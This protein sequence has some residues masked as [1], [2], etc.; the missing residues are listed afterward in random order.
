MVNQALSP[1]PQ[2]ETCQMPC[3]DQDSFCLQQSYLGYRW[4]VLRL[5]L[6]LLHFKLLTGRYPDFFFFFFLPYL[7][8]V[9]KRLDY[10][11]SVRCWI[12][13]GCKELMS[14][15]IVDRKNGYKIIWYWLAFIKPMLASKVSSEAIFRI[16]ILSK[17]EFPIFRQR[18]EKK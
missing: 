7:F 4:L 11:V 14:E 2:Q 17:I 16:R 8:P 9:T 18:W 3:F 15:W 12:Y 10:C 1:C 5:N 6:C 13:V